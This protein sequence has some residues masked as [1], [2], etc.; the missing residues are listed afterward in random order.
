M[1][2][3]QRVHMLNI[4]PLTDTDS[5]EQL[6][7]LLHRSYERLG[8]MGLNYTAVD[9]SVDTTAAR[10]QGGHCLLAL[11]NGQLAGT[12]LAKPTDTR[13]PCRYFAKPGVATLRQF[14]V[15]PAFQGRGIGRALVDR[16]EAWA[17]EAGFAEMALDTAEPAVHLVQ[18][19][20]HLGYQPVDAVQWRGKVYRSVVMSKA[21]LGT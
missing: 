2:G 10:I 3:I 12:V 21:L 13:S 18:M 5:L 17:R 4:R 19:Y 7:Q 11:W 9:Q 6:T 8:A 20:L 15:D 1:P 14:A 16:C